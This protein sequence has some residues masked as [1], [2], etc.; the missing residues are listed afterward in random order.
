MH[1]KLILI[2][3]RW[4]LIKGYFKTLMG[5]A[6][7]LCLI[8]VGS[9]GGGGGQLRGKWTC[10][11]FNENQEIVI[12]KARSRELVPQ[13]HVVDVQQCNELEKWRLQTNKP[14]FVLHVLRLIYFSRIPA[15]D[16]IMIDWRCDRHKQGQNP[17]R[18]WGK[19]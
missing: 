5:H 7:T 12:N 1:L 2:E 3:L 19:W 6:T 18:T 8:N 13:P 11:R 16:F 4:F 10:L 14:N 17:Q 9:G 15:G